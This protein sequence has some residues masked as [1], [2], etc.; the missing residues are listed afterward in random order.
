[1]IPAVSSM[2]H[3]SVLVIGGG[4]AGLA[5]ATALAPH[6][7]R[8][9]V[10]EARNRLGGRAASFVD[11][12]TGQQIDNCQHVSMG[13]CTQFARF[14]RTLGIERHLQSQPELYFMTPDGR[15][16]RLSADFLPAPFHL[17]RSFLRAH[18]LTVRDK[19]R[20]L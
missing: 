17:T 9:T 16:S 4:L 7:F 18:Y 8:V 6:G 15:V 5:A 12:A 14:C 13:C 1:M 3:S 19:L 2:P 20:L 11:T 10:L